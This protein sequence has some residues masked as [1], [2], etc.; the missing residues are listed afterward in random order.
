MITA[1][2]QLLPHL[3]Q[4]HHRP[5]PTAAAPTLLQAHHRTPTP[6]TPPAKVLPDPGSNGAMAAIQDPARAAAAVVAAAAQP[7]STLQR[8]QHMVSEPVAVNG[9]GCDVARSAVIRHSQTTSVH[10]HGSYLPS[11]RSVLNHAATGWKQL[12]HP[13][14]ISHLLQHMTGLLIAT[15]MLR[16]WNA[17]TE[18]GLL[19][20]FARG[21]ERQ[22]L[23]VVSKMVTA[24]PCGIKLHLES[25]T[26]IGAVAGMLLHVTERLL[27]P[28]ARSA[29]TVLSVTIGTGLCCGGL[30]L[31]LALAQD[32]ATALC[33]PLTCMYRI[34]CALYWL[35]LSGL[36]LTW[37]LLRGTHSKRLSHR[38]V[39]KAPSGSVSGSTAAGAQRV[40]ERLLT[41]IGTGPGPAAAAA[42]GGALWGLPVEAKEEI[43]M[44][45]LIVGVLLFVPLLLLLPTTAMWYLLLVVLHTCCLMS[46]LALC[47]A[48][49]LCASNPLVILALHAINPHAKTGVSVTVV[50]Y[51]V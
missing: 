39:S 33:A 51:N 30:S 18:S 13:A 36:A 45:E 32:I 19:T 4:H 14:T 47:A 37:G 7:D 11:L 10:A 24:E 1:V 44:E 16:N 40:K 6:A 21:C 9:K 23:D 42:E 22:L 48:Q 15:W 17:V 43:V 12:S 41:G 35:H 3:L 5:T 34:M 46:R 29:A 26:M 50:W 2:T 8:Q 49:K 20:S 28:A 38:R 27:S 31:G 25:S